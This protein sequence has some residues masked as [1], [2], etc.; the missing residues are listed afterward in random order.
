MAVGTEALRPPARRWSRSLDRKTPIAIGLINNLSG[1]GFAPTNEQFCGVLMEAAQSL[2]IQVNVLSSVV[3]GGP[4][5]SASVTFKN[6]DEMSELWAG[7]FD[8]LIVTGT[9]PKASRLQDEPSW[10][11]LSRLVEWCNRNV[12]SAVWSC[13]ATQAAVFHLDDIERQPFGTKLSGI[14]ECERVGGDAILNGFPARWKAPHS[15]YNDLPEPLLKARGYEIL[16][17]SPGWGADIFMKQR[18]STH[19]FMQGHLEYDPSVLSRE[20]KRDVRRFLAGESER[21]PEIPLEYYP[22][23]IVRALGTFRERA[24][25]ERSLNIFEF[26]PLQADMPP[27]PTPWRSVAVQFYRNWLDY[28]QRSKTAAAEEMSMGCETH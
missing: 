2:P 1:P 25:V 16:T 5:T 18:D 24:L 3:A 10:P 28:L 26:F 17:R 11:F 15:R 23:Q 8:G 12:A 27:K 7:K 20:Y 6:P 21:Y 9:E 19:F 13:M 14:L 4:E 22:E